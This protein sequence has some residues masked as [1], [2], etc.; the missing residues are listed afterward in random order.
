VEEE[1]AEGLVALGRAASDLPVEIG[2]RV[3]KRAAAVGAGVDGAHAAKL[4][5]AG[6]AGEALEALHQEI[7][8]ILLHAVHP[9][10]PLD[11]AARAL[12]GCAEAVGV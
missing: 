8:A 6:R 12:D 11:L 3:I 10:S 7:V 1:E 4:E 9:L 2:G 5:E